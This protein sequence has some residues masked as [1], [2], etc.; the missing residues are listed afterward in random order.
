MEKYK[1]ITIKQIDWLTYNKLIDWMIEWSEIEISC[2]LPFDR[3]NQ[4]Q[5]DW[6]M[7][8]EKVNLRFND[9]E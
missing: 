4:Q 8:V 2:T 5:N 1:N 6:F 9:C 3:H 7:N